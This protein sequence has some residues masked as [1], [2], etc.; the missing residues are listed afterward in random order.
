MALVARFRPHLFFTTG[1][2][3]AGP[4]GAA[5][6]ALGVPVVLMEPNVFPGLTVRILSRA[7]AQVHLNDPIAA[8]RVGGR[9][10]P[11]SGV[12][13]R[14]P[15]SDSDE[16]SQAQARNRLELRQDRPLLL[17]TGGSQ[18][19]RGINNAVLEALPI[20]AA[21]DFQILWQAGRLGIDAAATAAELWPGHVRAVEF[22][23]DMPTAYRAA[24]LTVSRAGA[25]TLAE[26][27]YY[28][29]P[30]ILV[31]LPTA[32]ENHQEYNARSAERRGAARV[33]LQEDLTGRRL[34]ET[35]IDLVK[36]SSRLKHMKGRSLEAA[37]P[38]AAE[39]IVET[40]RSAGLLRGDR[41]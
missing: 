15:D 34:A 9:Q 13:F 37:R 41:R 7:A 31:P 10:K 20:L 36:D 24:D 22:I 8:R 25:G 19:A 21:A 12:P 35:V 28:G 18:G 5:A 32:A 38:N 26:Q 23:D 29:V 2:Y 33:I 27:S 3:L 14:T 17:V 4:V 11:C 39:R 30:A 6:R 16:N 40:M 1:G